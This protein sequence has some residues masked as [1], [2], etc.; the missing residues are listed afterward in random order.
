[1][2]EREVRSPWSSSKGDMHPRRA[3]SPGSRSSPSNAPDCYPLSSRRDC[4]KPT[5][6]VGSGGAAELERA[7]DRGM[8]NDRR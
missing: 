8:R 4:V 6:V 2:G 5:P 7:M 3:E 1:M